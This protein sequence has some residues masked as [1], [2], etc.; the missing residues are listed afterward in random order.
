L[1]P[2]LNIGKFTAF[3]SPTILAGGEI[4]EYAVTVYLGGHYVGGREHVEGNW[5]LAV[6]AA[7]EIIAEHEREAK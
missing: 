7:K 1:I 4:T 3:L 2:T 5:D 6:A